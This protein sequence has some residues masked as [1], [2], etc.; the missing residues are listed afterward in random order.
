MIYQK[1]NQIVRPLQKFFDLYLSLKGNSMTF[2]EGDF[3]FPRFVS[4]NCMS[5][6]FL[7]V[8]PTQA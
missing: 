3:I 7:P 8:V 5:R 6:E 2:S 1:M 4:T